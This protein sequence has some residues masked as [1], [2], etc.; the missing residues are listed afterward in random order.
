MTKSKRSS[1]AT[2]RD[3][4]GPSE[5][6]ILKALATEVMD[7]EV[8]AEVKERRKRNRKRAE[9]DGVSLAHLDKVYKMRDEPASEVEKFFRL[10]WQHFSAFF[11]DLAEQLD[12]FVPKLSVERRSAHR[13]V[14]KMAGLTGKPGKAPDGLTP[15]EVNMWMD[16]WHDGDWAREASK[17]ASLEAM[18][19]ALENAD[20]G[21]VTDGTKG[22]KNGKAKEVAMKAADDF[23]DDNPEVTRPEPMFQ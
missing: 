13:H 16:G 7:Q 9:A 15:D 17:D 22:R 1:P 14:G 11:T 18:K 4:N 23:Y 10:Q 2:G 8:M 19:E 20:K 12:L 21:I 3:S 6:A 5:E